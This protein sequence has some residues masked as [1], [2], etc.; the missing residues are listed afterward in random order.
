MTHRLRAR[1]TVL[2]IGVVL[3]AGATL[4]GQGPPVGVRPW[5]PPRTAD[6]QPDIQG[7]WNSIDAFF[8]PLQRPTKLGEK[9]AVTDQE[10]RAV[11]EEEATRKLDA[12]DA[13]TGAYGH[14][15][16]EYKR[17]VIRAAPSLIVD[18][19]DGRIPAMTPWARD[20]IA[21]MRARQMHDPESMDPGDRCIS[22]GILGEMLPT[23]YN[24]G[25]QIIQTPGYVTIVSE[26]IHH[27]RVIPLDNRPRPPDSVRA[28]TGVPRGRWEGATLV[29]ESTHFSR[30]DVLRNIGIQTETLKMT[31]RFTPVD[32]D[33]LMYRITIEDPQVYTAPWTIEFPFVRDNG[34]RMFEYGCHEGNHAIENM[35][36]GARA[37]ERR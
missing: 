30:R 27:A 7:L 22:R 1:L 36:R 28:W 31:E 25:K 11:L 33:T 35:L 10:L 21:H 17:N 14:E 18:P 23:F 32:P 3:A 16:Y 8:T 2:A 20:R 13:G 4:R 26:M 24:N 34:Y 29:V 6:G 9:P 5:T 19:P 37:E 15:W 12:A